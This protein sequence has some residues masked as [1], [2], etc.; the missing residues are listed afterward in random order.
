MLAKRLRELSFLNSGACIILRD[1]RT[2]AEEIFEYKGGISSFVEHLSQNKTT[3]HNKVIEITGDRDGVQVELS[4]QWNDSYQENV[5]CYTNNIPQRDGGTHLSGF[6]AALTRSLNQ[7][8]DSTGIA[9]KAKVSVSGDDAREGLIAVLSVK[10]PDPKF[11]SQTKD[12]L[13]SSEV[14]GI[15]D[16][17]VSEKLSEFL[18]EN[19]TDGRVISQKIVDSARARDAARKARDMTRRKGALEISGLPG[20]LADCQERDP[21]LCEIYLVEGDSAGGS[22][23]QA[24]DRKFQAIL[25]LKGKILNVEKARFDKMLSSDEVGTLIKALGTGIGKDDFDET[26]LR[27]HR[28]IIMT[29][30]DVD[31]SHIRTLLLTF[32]YRQM[33]ELV[34]TGHIYIAQPPL[35]KLTKGKKEKYIKDDLELQE[36]LLGQALEEAVLSTGE[37]K[38]E[39]SGKSLEKLCRDYIAA[40][41]IISRLSQRYDPY[42]L[43]L[44]IKIPEITDEDFKDKA[45]MQEYLD[46]IVIG[47]A[48]SKEGEITYSGQ[49]IASAND[50]YE[51]MITRSKHGTSSN[52]RFD[53]ALFKSAEYR[54]LVLLGKT[55]QGLLAEDASIRVRE[56]TQAVSEFSEALN[57]MM[58]QARKGIAIQRYKGL[59]EMNPDQLWETTMD[60]EVR[61]LLQVTVEDGVAADETFSML[62]GEIVE[63]RRKFI[64]DNAFSANLDV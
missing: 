39:L 62:M 63:P 1:D 36:H 11:S 46:A 34:E 9:K 50:E 45:R 24:R 60:P 7:Y 16:S 59:G 17:L 5:F 25:P 51:I 12:K 61:R 44:M 29:D 3:L 14:K 15:V 26:K 2:N 54:T 52:T 13:V 56:K 30:A 49:L 40:Q 32:F 55:L 33:K 41:A 37:G 10:V 27:Y 4:M 42:L 20:K 23:K 43:Q 64:E 48:S 28:I 6:R 57:W 19:P 53:T 31:G 58:L 18:L 38:E 47:S 21:S 35:Y 8:I 22:A